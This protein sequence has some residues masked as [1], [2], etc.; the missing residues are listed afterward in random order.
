MKRQKFDLTKMF[1]YLAELRA[2]AETDMYSATPYLQK[3]FG[4]DG[5][6]AKEIWLAWM[7]NYLRPEAE[8]V[9]SDFLKSNQWS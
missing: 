4:L 6:E 9:L 5:V 3:K 7:T 8:W 2:S 1:A